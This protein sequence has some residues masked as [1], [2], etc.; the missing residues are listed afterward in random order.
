MAP[1]FTRP[2]LV[3]LSGPSCSGKTTL[4]RLLQS[5]F[6]RT[7]L[8]HEDDFYLPAAQIPYRSGVQNWDCAGALDL[9][10]LISVLR[11]VRKEGRLPTGLTSKEEYE[12]SNIVDQGKQ[13]ELRQEIERWARGKGLVS[14]AT[15]A[16]FEQAQDEPSVVLLDGILLFGKS[17]TEVSRELDLRMLLRGEYEDIKGRRESRKGYITDEGFWE[18]PE[19]YVD[20]IVWPE[21]AEEHAFLFEGGDV[22]AAVSE[23]AARNADIQV[24][25]EQKIADML[26]WAV[27]KLKTSVENSEKVRSDS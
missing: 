21:Y 13:Q 24:C 3:G 14:L 19:G 27:A 5:V 4:A 22:Q 7:V 25:P 18:D 26:S 11:H 1:S 17:T 9:P 8:L 2:L 6:P 12:E 20:L 10:R 16:D 15:K 23:T